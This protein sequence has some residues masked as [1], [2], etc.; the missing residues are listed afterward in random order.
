MKIIILF[1]SL[2][3]I[4]IA[5]LAQDCSDSCG[6][7]GKESLRTNILKE[8]LNTS[9]FNSIVHI[10]VKRI[11]RSTGSPSTASFIDSNVLITANHSLIRSPFISDITLKMNGMSIKLKKRDFKIYH[12]HQGLFHKE[13]KDIAILVLKKDVKDVLRSYSHFQLANFDLIRDTTHKF[14][15]TG[16]PFDRPDTLVDKTTGYN[17][18]KKEPSGKVVGYGLYTCK[19]DS[20]APL[21][22]E[23][24][25]IFKV[26]SIH[27]GKGGLPEFDCKTTNWGIKV[28]SE[29]VEWVNRKK[30]IH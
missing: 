19:G 14:H 5:L 22:Y 27:H 25:G 17:D 21:W 30:V 24:N 7:A 2:M 26:V 8:E 9:P 11:Y 6:P 10:V 29:V 15:L 18:L 1:N 20:G 12:F 13:N 16:F 28:T 4:S 23:D 3:L